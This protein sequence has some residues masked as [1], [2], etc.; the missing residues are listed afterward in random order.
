MEN[1]GTKLLNECVLNNITINDGLS[2][3]LAIVSQ[4]FYSYMISGEK[5][6]ESRFSINKCSPY[7][8]VKSKDIMFI[9]ESG[10]PITAYLTIEKVKFF[11]KEDNL[12]LNNL[13]QKYA[14][15][16]CAFDDSFWNDRIGKNYVSLMWITNP[17]SITPFS[18]EKK[19][20]R[21]WIDYNL[22]Y[23]R[24]IIL[25]SGKIG[26]GKTYWAEKISQMFKCKRNS[27]S[28]YLKLICVKE[29]L[30]VNRVNLQKIGQ[31]VIDN[32]FEDF[33]KY[34]ALNNFTNNDV[35]VVDGLRH[36]ECIDYFKSVIK[37][38]IHININP[39][40]EFRRYNIVLRDGQ[41]NEQLD[42]SET[43]KQSEELK[44]YCNYIINEYTDERDVFKFINNSI[45][46]EIQN[47]QMNIFEKYWQ[48][49]DFNDWN[50]FL[51]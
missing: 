28:D 44:E 43:E 32:Q 6:I 20:K 27:F 18:I 21:G 14:K 12:D 35:L 36:K 7:K 3:H 23:P 13:K 16:I 37:N 49:N 5:T 1:I 51:L 39:S 24:T 2:L 19:D 15:E 8:K 9:K 29:K 34:I 11:S 30:E 50:H 10:K 47:C 4:P 41:Y 25:I 38:V 46:Y 33:M 48:K 45:K 26:S 40:E 22:K 31:F 17:I 42:K